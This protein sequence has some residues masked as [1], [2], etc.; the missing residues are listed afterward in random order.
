MI[1]EDRLYGLSVG[2]DKE[3]MYSQW[4]NIKNETE[5]KLQTVCS[6]FRILVNMMVPIRRQLPH[7]LETFWVRIGLISYLIQ[8]FL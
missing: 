8:I 2:A 3:N 5:S 7:I 1:L 4:K 6:F